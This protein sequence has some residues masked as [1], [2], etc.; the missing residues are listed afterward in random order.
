[1]Q[2]LFSEAKVQEALVMTKTLSFDN[3]HS[4]LAVSEELFTKNCVM[5]AFFTIEFDCH[6]GNK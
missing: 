3:Y 4:F 2:I 5:A 6:Q 1:M